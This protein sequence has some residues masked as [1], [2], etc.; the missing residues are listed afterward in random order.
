MVPTRG[1]KMLTSNANSN[2]QGKRSPSIGAVARQGKHPSSIG[3]VLMV[4]SA[5]TPR[6]DHKIQAP[7]PDRRRVDDIS[8]TKTTRQGKHP[9]STGGVLMVASALVGNSR[10][11]RELQAHLPDGRRAHDISS[12]KTTR[13]AHLLPIACVTINYKRPSPTGG[14]NIASHLQRLRCPSPKGGVPNT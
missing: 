8:S 3:G 4:A 14:V 12:T 6:C 1:Q 11:Y 5:P 9:S 13:Q 7:L 2:Y 10:L